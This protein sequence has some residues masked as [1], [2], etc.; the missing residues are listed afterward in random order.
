[1]SVGRVRDIRSLESA[2]RPDAKGVVF[3]QPFIILEENDTHYNMPILVPC[4]TNPKTLTITSEVRFTSTFILKYS[5][6][7]LL[8]NIEFVFN[9]QHDCRHCKCKPTGSEPIR[10]ER[11]ETSRTRRTLQHTQMERYLLNMHALHNADLIRQILP[12]HHWAPK[13]YVADRKAAHQEFAAKA[14]SLGTK[15]RE[16]TAAKA[17]ATRARKKAAVADEGRAGEAGTSSASA[18]TEQTNSFGADIENE[19]GDVAGGGVAS[20]VMP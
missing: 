16:E 11:H 14:R 9:A 8:Q 20:P 5:L 1:M 7:I 2:N 6:E 10:Q 3:I 4:P 13:C 19:E 12:R 15:K 17:A 18:P